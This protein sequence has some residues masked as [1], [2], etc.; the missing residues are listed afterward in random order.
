MFIQVVPTSGMTKDSLVNV[1]HVQNVDLIFQDGQWQV[2]ID[3]YNVATCIAGPTE[4]EE[5]ARRIF[6]LVKQQLRSS[7]LLIVHKIG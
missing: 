5:D 1:N 3:Q 2:I 4:N 6:D 7:N